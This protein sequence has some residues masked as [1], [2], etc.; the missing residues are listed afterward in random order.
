MFP[1]ILGSIGDASGKA[2]AECTW[3]GFTDYNLNIYI[4]ENLYSFFFLTAIIGPAV[5]ELLELVMFVVLFSG[6][7]FVF[8]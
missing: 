6:S 1:A 8:I 7:P 3:M 5:E 4:Y 2:T